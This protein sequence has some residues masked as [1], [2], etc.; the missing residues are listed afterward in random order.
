MSFTPWSGSGSGGGD[1]PYQFRPET[2]GAK[3]DGRVIGD[4][5]INSTTTFTSAS[6]GFTAADTGKTI[7]INGGQ[8][9]GGMPLITTITFVNSTTVTLA[10]AA[11]ATATG[12]SAVYGTDDT[13]A[14][15]AAVSAAATYAEVND[16]FAEIVFGSKIYCLASGPTQTAVVNS[17]IPLPYP[18]VNGTTRKLVLTFRGAGDAS[19]TQYF[20]STIPNMQGTCLTSMVLAPSAVDPTFGYQSVIGGPSKFGSFTG[21]FANVKPVIDG[22]TVWCPALSNNWAFDFTSVSCAHVDRSAALAFASVAGNQPNLPNFNNIA[23]FTSRASV[24]LGMP[25]AGNNDDCVVGAFTTE[26]FNIGYWVSE[27]FNAQRIN[28]IY[29]FIGVLV[30]FTLHGGTT[31]HGMSV[32]YYSAEANGYNLYTNATGG[33]QYPI[34]IGLMDAESL[35]VEDIHD[36]NSI[37]TGKVSWAAFDKAAPVVNGGAGLQ[38]LNERLGHGHWASPPAVPASATPQQNTAWR[39]AWVVLTSGGAAVTGIAVD[40]TTTG[41][42]L[43]TTGSVAVRVPS[44]KS[45]TLTYASTAPTWAWWLD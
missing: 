37:F 40:G 17:Q 41:L 12:C 36:P 7:M 33:Q 13:A 19:N 16:W 8:G 38:V 18:N 10:S 26:G 1:Q 15:N 31:L 29:T 9:T 45:I 23:F 25:G 30:D 42:T 14:I 5:T 24:G 22:I 43:G 27:H 28:A 39:D 32:L 6:A 35:Q 4:G 3:G 34:D 20:D 2:Y 11:T 44:G 21:G